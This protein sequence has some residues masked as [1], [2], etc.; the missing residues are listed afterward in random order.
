MMKLKK[1]SIRYDPPGM[2]IE[3]ECVAG[4]MRQRIHK[5]LPPVEE[6]T[7]LE[8]IRAL[9]D[10][11]IEECE[12]GLLEKHEKRL[13][14]LLGRLYKIDVVA[15]AEEEPED[16]QEKDTIEEQDDDEKNISEDACR[17]ETTAEPT[18]WKTEEEE[19]EAVEQDEEVV[20][21]PTPAAVGAEPIFP[22]ELPCPEEAEAAPPDPGYDPGATFS[23]T[24]PKMI[25]EDAAPAQDRGRGGRGAAGET[26]RTIA[27]P[28]SCST[29]LCTSRLSCGEEVRESPTPAA[30][31]AEPPTPMLGDRKKREDDD[32]EAAPTSTTSFP[33]GTRCVCVGLRPGRDKKE[34][35]G[36]RRRAV[37][38]QLLNGMLGTIS[39]VYPPHEDP[40]SGERTPPP[41]MYLVSFDCG[42]QLPVNP[43][44]L[45]QVLNDGF[46]FK[47]GLLKAGTF[48]VVCGLENHETLNGT[49]GRITGVWT[50][51][52]SFRY[53][54]ECQDTGRWFRVRPEKV[55]AALPLVE[56]AEIPSALVEAVRKERHE[57]EE[58]LR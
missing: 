56:G 29:R 4:S 3:C 51:Y 52:E 46:P 50:N 34:P 8:L 15:A 41:S 13:I 14:E 2:L 19:E 57:A 44:D 54:V 33:L 28:S 27:A 40:R 49:T 22:V 11:I 31:G 48:V 21:P 26:M 17:V 43:E 25:P 10:L 55:L 18:D 45:L 7:S 37:E 23:A 24:S 35:V 32:D 42:L 20:E 58:A 36:S 5:D 1:I 47:A 6:I 16:E 39:A 9:A 30:G 38:L 12:D 53:E